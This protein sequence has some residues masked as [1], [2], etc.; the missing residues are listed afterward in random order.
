MTRI[1]PG[2]LD[3]LADDLEPVRPIDHK[4]AIVGL[5]GFALLGLVAVGTIL[6]SRADILAGQPGA[7]FIFRTLMLLALGS[8]TAAA[9]LALARPGVG[10]ASRAWMGA[11]AMAALVPVT[12]LIL[13]VADPASAFQAVW[14]P[15]AALCLG[16]SLTA[17]TGF[18]AILVLH[19]RRGAPVS[20]ARAGTLVGLA[21]GSLGVL[22][23]SLH[24]PANSVIYIG[25][26]YGL[27]IL[28]STLVARQIVP[29]LI[30]W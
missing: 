6:G 14:W 21:S 16:V 17:A 4:R 22:V 15:S 9:T 7:V 11:L 18:G 23:Y 27:A 25:L 12:A 19:L 26:W 24:C 28:A 3:R 29:R 10:R 5:T 13:A 1:D 30:R 2:F 20:P 8:I